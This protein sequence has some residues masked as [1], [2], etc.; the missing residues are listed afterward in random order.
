MVDHDVRDCRFKSYCGQLCLSCHCNIQR[1]IRAAHTYYNSTFHSPWD[2]DWAKMI[3]WRWMAAAFTS[4][5]T[6]QVGWIGT[7][8]LQPLVFSLHS[9]SEMAKPLQWLCHDD[10]TN[11]QQTEIHQRVQLLC[12][13]CH[14]IKVTEIPSSDWHN[15][16]KNNRTQHSV[17]LWTGLLWPEVVGSANIVSPQHGHN[18]KP[19][20]TH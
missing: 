9:S 15:R 11:A 12:T 3:K 18:F 17:E 19:L 20:R 16:N 5:H 4:R 1:W 10:S 6:D 8:G 7:R 13:T 2:G 14:A